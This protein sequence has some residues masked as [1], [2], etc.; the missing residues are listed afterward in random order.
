MTA[1]KKSAKK[2][3]QKSSKARK[4]RKTPVATRRPAGELIPIDEL[5]TVGAGAAGSGADEF[6]F[7]YVPRR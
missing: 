2:P 7:L 1:R 3:A 4:S 6:F 5:E